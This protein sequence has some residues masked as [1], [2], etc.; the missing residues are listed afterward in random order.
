MIISLSE[1]SQHDGGG[2]AVNLA[3]LIRAGYRVPEGFV[4]T[5]RA[6]HEVAKD[7]DV[8]SLFAHHGAAGVREALVGTELPADIVSALDAHLAPLG[9]SV[10]VAVR[11]S[12]T[13]E[14]LPD[15]SFAGQQDT[16]LGVCGT[17]DVARAVR[18]CWASLWSDRAVAYRE[19]QGIDHSLVA[20]AVIV[21]RLIDAHSAGVAFTA[22]PST[23]ERL[24][25]ISAS[26]GLGESV[27]S[28]IVSADEYRVREGTISRRIGA[29]EVRCD[30]V[31][32]EVVTTPL[33]DQSTTPCL[34]EDQV[35]E[36]VAV[37]DRV[38]DEFG[39]PMDLEWAYDAEG[40][41]LLQARPITTIG[42]DHSGTVAPQSRRGRRVSRL[43]QSLHNDSVE[44]YPS[45]F[46]L[47]L[48]AITRIDAQLQAGMENIGVRSTPLSELI[49]MAP[50]GVV[51]LDYP[52][53]RFTWKLVRLLRYRAP[54]PREWPAVEHEFRRRAS[55]LTVPGPDA[56]VAEILA[57]LEEVMALADDIIRTRF[58]DYIGPAMLR[59]ARL[60]LVLALAG[61]RDL[62]PY[63]LLANLDYVSARIDREIHR[64]AALS[65]HSPDTEG[66]IEAFVRTWG[67]RTSQ[68]YLPFSQRSWR[69]DPRPLYLTLSALRGR[70]GA[71][72]P[73]AFAETLESL[74][75]RVPRCARTRVDRLV[76][77]WR[78]G[79]CAREASLY[80][81]EETYV[82]ARAVR[83][84]LAERMCKTGHLAD[85]EDI[86]FLTL[87]EVSEA[88][89]GNLSPA[90]TREMIELRR[91]NR[92]R[93]QSHWWQLRCDAAED[94][95]TLTG[96]AG[97]PGVATGPAR[98]ITSPTEFHRLRPGDV[99]VCHYTDPTWTPLFSVASAVVAD[100]GAQ[101]SHAA[102]VAREYA[103][104]AVMGT[105]T[106]TERIRDGQLVTVNGTNG[107]VIPHPSDDTPLSRRVRQEE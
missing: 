99:L 94:D 93:A 80:L 64:L 2:K 96:V 12:A 77:E 7:L 5:T 44:H 16:V 58:I 55:A 49:S 70:A 54:D 14:D 95:R 101:L 22:D 97:S 18:H 50:D 59:A 103:I 61:R 8:S 83:D 89:A 104:P 4:L 85:A 30:R 28:G 63:D 34:S 71:H 25:L 29:K 27:V 67:A 23:G 36:I 43:A 87:D 100:T 107:S 56:P 78:A 52:R 88:G 10:A 76:D 98:I 48:A 82:L 46:P 32:R 92:P 1:A 39:Q 62:T 45:P 11:S 65:P 74:H 72:S 33:P 38:H 105:R 81:V 73:R 86:R 17:A 41:W 84:V 15:A 102:I 57:A 19:R 35:R 79:H 66:E 37:A 106:A 3:R 51:T 20:I 47:D 21:Q 91:R 6:Y 53:V 75:A 13:A 60:K 40:L 9:E 42:R 26:W 24:T 31:G 90:H 69:E 68:T